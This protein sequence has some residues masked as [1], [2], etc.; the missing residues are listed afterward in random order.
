M[1]A[2][3]FKDAA[4]DADVVA[5]VAVAAIRVAAITKD[6][7]N[8]DTTVGVKVH[9]TKQTKAPATKTTRILTIK[10]VGAGST[11]CLNLHRY[12]PSLKM[13]RASITYLCS[14][15]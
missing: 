14:A 7:V 6:V 5:V 1:A 10:A 12:N 8:A 13:L 9:T 11:P 15:P 4:L 3:A 2:A